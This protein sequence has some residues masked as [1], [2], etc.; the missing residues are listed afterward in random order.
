[1]IRLKMSD[2]CCAQWSPE[3]RSC[4][5]VA[6]SDPAQSVPLTSLFCSFRPLTN[7]FPSFD[8]LSAWI[9]LGHKYQMDK[10]VEDSLGYLRRFYPPAYKP[11]D[12]S[13][14]VPVIEKDRPESITGVHAI[15]VVN[16][17]HFTG[18]IDLLPLAL[19][20]CCKLDGTIMHGFTREDGTVERLSAEDLGRCFG[21]KATMVL[22]ASQACFSALERAEL[23]R[24]C[25][26]RDICQT[27]LARK[28]AEY[29]REYPDL[30]AV[31]TLFVRGLSESLITPNECCD[32]CRQEIE[33]SIESMRGVRWRY[34]P[35]D[36]DL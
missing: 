27:G 32:L 20:E 11:G 8:A 9:R 26:R 35:D 30:I 17:A 23:S 16:L 2:I 15:G 1:M 22:H 21:A 3:G 14:P 36:F 24:W 18:S 12:T 13:R 29:V 25:Q 33:D 28:R 10:L 6:Y 34:L 4:E 31:D 19:L 5:P 7:P